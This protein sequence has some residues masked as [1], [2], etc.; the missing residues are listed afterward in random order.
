MESPNSLPRLALNSHLPN[1]WPPRPAQ[2]C[3]SSISLGCAPQPCTCL[4][5]QPHPQALHSHAGAPFHWAMPS[6]PAQSLL[7]QPHPQGL[8]SPARSLL[9]HAPRPDALEIQTGMISIWLGHAPKAG[10]ALQELH[11]ARPCP[12]P[13]MIS[14]L[15]ATPS[16]L[17]QSYK[18]SALPVHASK[19]CHA[20]NTN[21]RWS[22]FCWSPFTPLKAHTALHNI[23]SASLCP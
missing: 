15:P 7:C 22:P 13:C 3:R 1:L 11:F 16:R 14:A 4:L 2:P 23:H 19:V 20:G 18:I 17:E 12:K 8:H 9:G 5:C 21:P 6:S 10:T